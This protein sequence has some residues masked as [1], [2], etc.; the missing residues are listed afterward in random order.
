M[1]MAVVGGAL[2]GTEAN[3]GMVA[4]ERTAILSG[5]TIVAAWVARYAA[6]SPGRRLAN[7]LMVALAM[8]LLWDDLRAGTPLTMFLSFACVGLAL[9]VATKLRK[10]AVVPGVA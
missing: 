9:I 2:H 8:K 4:F 6:L 10:S 1:L 3:G 5:L 7:I